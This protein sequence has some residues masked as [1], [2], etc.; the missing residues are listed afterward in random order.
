MDISRFVGGLVGGVLGGMLGGSALFGIVV[1][2]LKDRWLKGVEARNSEALER[3]KDE[4]QRDQ[5]TLQSRLDHG[6]YVTQAQ[7]DLELSSYRDLWSALSELR[8]RWR[9]LFNINSFRP[10]SGD[11]TEFE[12]AMKKA[13][14]DL[15][16]AH[17]AAVLV[18]GRLAPFYEKG[19]Q[20]LAQQTAD[21]SGA[22]AHNIKTAAARGVPRP[23]EDNVRDLQALCDAIEAIDALIRTRL[24]KLR[25]L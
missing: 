6:T 25:L 23:F 1:S 7:Y 13:E 16:T 22:F 5:K 17:D 24:G 20:V 14:V 19:I 18:T 12:N 8:E 2:L 9:G 4:L 11:M 15:S 3:V 21:A 10:A